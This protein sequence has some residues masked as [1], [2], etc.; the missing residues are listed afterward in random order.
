MIASAT[1]SRPTLSVVTLVNRAELYNVMRESLAEQ[2]EPEDIQWLP[3][4]ADARSLNAAQGLNDGIN[5][6]TGRWIICA[7]QDVLFPEGWWRLAAPQLE[8]WPGNLGVAGLVG[9]TRKGQYRGHVLDPH[10]HC[11][12]NPTPA[13][14]V[15]LDEHVL[16]LPGGTELRFDEANPGFHCYA[17]DIAFSAR[18][19][20]LD[21]IVI[22][23]PVIHLSGGNIDPAFGRCSRWLLGK[24]GHTCGGVIPTCCGVFSS[25]KLRSLFREARARLTMR[26][27]RATVRPP[28][29][30]LTG[31]SGIYPASLRDDT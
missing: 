3:I 18:A 16:I 6:A 19:I 5:R 4:D 20:G 26:A 13:R 27:S 22:G 12:W 17:T 7:H 31:K 29:G 30:T 24:W 28:K 9:V 23:A 1:K 21:S 15:S 25:R 11:L 10:G 8:S 14:V 2:F